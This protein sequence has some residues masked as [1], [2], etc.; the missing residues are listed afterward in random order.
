MFQNSCEECI[1]FKI[2]AH[3]TELQEC[4]R[5]RQKKMAWHQ[6][7][8]G[9]FYLECKFCSNTVSVDVQTPCEQDPALSRPVQLEIEPQRKLPEPRGILELAKRFGIRPEKMEIKLRE[10]SREMIPVYYVGGFTALLDMY[11]VA[12]RYVDFEDPRDRYL[13]FESCRYPYSKMTMFL[14]KENNPY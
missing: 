12:W 13:F 6:N 11:E 4:P 7:F 1:A 10:G 5:C 3:Q 9:T 8:F 2:H 14:A